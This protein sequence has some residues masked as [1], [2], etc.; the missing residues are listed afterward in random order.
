VGSPRG[1]ILCLHGIQS[2]GGWYESSS[3]RL[4]EAGFV[5]TYLDR[6]GSGANQTA[7]GDTP[8]FR[9]LLAD[10]HEVLVHLRMEQPLLPI[11]LSACSWGGKLALAMCRP[12]R[13]DF[14][15]L[16]LLCPGFFPKVVPPLA[17]RLG[18]FSARW[19][20]PSRMFSI[21]LNDPVL[22]TA[23]PRHR[24]FIAHDPL[25][26]REATARFFFESVRLDLYL[27]MVPRHV[28][29]P[30]LLLLAEHDRIIDNARTRRFAQRFASRIVEYPGTHHTLEF[31]P[32][33][34]FFI[35]ELIEWLGTQFADR[36]DR[37]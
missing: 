6:R 10:V 13:K 11:A 7:R 24:Q 19:F 15:A 35:E 14:D 9:R 37:T 3:A 17:T 28:R 21:P 32:Q 20:A 27:R 31:E 25:A 5:V 16:A 33:P 22:F 26:L 8:T 1:Q 12:Y 18:I 30:V 29:V 23:T 36:H 2:H 4:A 34:E